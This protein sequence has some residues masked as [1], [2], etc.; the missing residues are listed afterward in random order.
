MNDTQ[1][2]EP[3]PQVVPLKDTTLEDLVDFGFTCAAIAAVSNFFKGLD[4]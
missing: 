3:P 2:N 1:N 4:E